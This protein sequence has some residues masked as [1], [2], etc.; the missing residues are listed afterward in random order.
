M[1]ICDILNC[2][3]DILSSRRIGKPSDE[4]PKLLYL[5]LQNLKQVQAV[6]YSASGL[7]GNN[8]YKNVS[9]PLIVRQWIKKNFANYVMN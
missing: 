8:Q 9:Y 2:P 7:K 5:T 1:L 4:K 6:L 3:A